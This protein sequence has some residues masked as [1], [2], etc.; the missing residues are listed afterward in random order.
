MAHCFLFSDHRDAGNIL[1]RRAAELFLRIATMQKMPKMKKFPVS[2]PHDLHTR[3]KTLCAAKG[4]M[5]TD[6][7]R[8]LLADECEAAGKA[9][10]AQPASR[11]EEI[12]A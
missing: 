1:K 12:A 11:R 7:V 6:V 2:V 10:K 5:M 3:F 9:T 4:V 8:R